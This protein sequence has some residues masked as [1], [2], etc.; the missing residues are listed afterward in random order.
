MQKVISLRTLTGGGGGAEESSGR[1]HC[2]R[3]SAAARRPRASSATLTSVVLKCTATGIVSTRGA[4]APSTS[5]LQRRSGIW[6]LRVGDSTCQS[7]GPSWVPGGK[8]I[9]ERNRAEAWCN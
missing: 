9:I 1:G 7:N 2:R 6:P 4:F 5:I 3:T 8:P